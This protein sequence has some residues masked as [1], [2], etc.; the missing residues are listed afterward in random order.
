[1]TNNLTRSTVKY[2]LPFEIRNLNVTSIVEGVVAAGISLAVLCFTWRRLFL[3]VNFTDEAFYIALPYRFSLGDIPIRDEQNLAQ[4]AGFLLVPFTRAFLHL[5]GSTEGIVLF[6][7]H[8]HLGFTI[9]I[10][11]CVFVVI[12]RHLRWPVA[13]M[14]SAVCVAFVPFNIHGLSY[15]T[16][17]CGF[18]TA[19]C[20]LGLVEN[21]SRI[22]SGASYF[23]SGVCH[24]LAVLSYPTLIIAVFAY[25][26][27][28]LFFGDC[29][30]T[31]LAL[32]ICGGLLVA[33]IPTILALRAGAESIRA[34]MEYVNNG[35]QGGGRE[36][37]REVFMG[38]TLKSP[39]HGAFG[40]AVTMLVVWH[41]FKPRWLRYLLPLL[42][43]LLIT[44][45]IS[46]ARGVR[47]YLEAHYLINSLGLSGLFL[48]PFIAE[49]RF[50]KRLYQFVLCPSV[51]G[52]LVTA[53]S[54]S[55]GAVNSAIGMFPASLASLILAVKAL[56][57]IPVTTT[58]LNIVRSSLTMITPALI[59]LPLMMGGSKYLYGGGSLF[60]ADLTEEVPSGP[61]GG[62]RTTAD[63]KAFVERF[64]R[65]ADRFVHPNDT[66]MF[67]ANFPAGYLFPNARPVTSSL[68]FTTRASI[69]SDP[70]HTMDYFQR[71]GTKPDVVFLTREAQGLSGALYDML[72]GE[73]YRKIYED[74]FCSIFRRQP[75][76]PTQRMETE[77]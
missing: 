11:S 7:R 60:T 5:Q 76:R 17:G 32:Y 71:T 67:F 56:Q 36:K 48:Y 22:T 51:L 52:G 68:F 30:R 54:S 28:I 33:L 45:T 64:S 16:L 3:G 40:L 1:M 31:R 25:G 74:D 6:F 75:S 37:L 58:L 49:D 35:P 4:F 2:A 65:V 26:A 50:G 44:Y 42:P 12:R 19:G 46:T 23:I 20:F 73:G 63:R 61:Y 14:I 41:L 47:S 13:L 24:G 70:S 57:A 9:V 29:R 72:T 39:H 77:G 55:N 62:I 66:V 15:N 69:P 21:E 38:L 8:L 59:L 10:G 43:M 18:L 34:A 53:W 27:A